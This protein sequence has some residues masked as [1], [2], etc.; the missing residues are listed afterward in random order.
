MVLALCGMYGEV[1]NEKKF[2]AEFKSRLRDCFCQEWFSHLD[3]ST[4]FQLYSCFKTCLE[5]EKYVNWI[6]ASNYL[7]TLAR[8]RLGVSEINAHRYR[9]A[10]QSSKRLCP[11]CPHSVE[12]EMHVV[13][14]CPVYADLRDKYLT[15]K[16]HVPLQLQLVN[17]FQCATDDIQHRLSKFLFFCH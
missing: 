3:N 5:R 13:F 16:R 14:N 1:G 17:L 10:D 6:H 9:F 15:V 2:I 12:N 11:F 8:F 4:H 7:K